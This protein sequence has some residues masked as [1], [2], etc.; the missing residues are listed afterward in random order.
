MSDHHWVM[1]AGIASFLLFAI[2]MLMQ[3]SGMADIPKAWLNYSFIGG[4]AGMGAG[5]L[6]DR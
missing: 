3:V 5:L 1:A 4:L 2:L 6:S